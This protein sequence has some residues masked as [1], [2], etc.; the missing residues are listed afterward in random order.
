MEEQ[1]LMDIR[2]NVHI[3]SGVDDGLTLEY[4]SKNGD[5]EL[6]PD[7]WTVNIGRRDE[8]DICLRKDT[9]VSRVHAKLHWQNQQWWLEDCNSTNGT[10]INID[11]DFFNDQQVKGFIHLDDDQLFRV[12][13]TW[14]R[15]QTMTE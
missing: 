13:R 8:N 14:L 3:M 1:W 9:Y 15:I 10:F 5:G 4:I 2:L 6:S 11:G 7:R 12:G